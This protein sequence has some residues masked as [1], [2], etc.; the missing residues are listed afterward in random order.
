[1]K[2]IF[3]IFTF[4]S[5]FSLLFAG[6]KDSL[7]YANELY[8]QGEYAL[9]ARQYEAIIAGKS[10]AP[11]IY[12]N[13]GNAYYKM[14]ETGRAI[15]NYERALHLSPNYDDAKHNLELTKLKIVDNIPM[16]ESF[17][18]LRWV[19]DLIKTLSSNHW[20]YVS[21]GLFA[22]ALLLIFAF[23]FGSSQSVRKSSF[24]TAVLFALLSVLFFRES[25]KTSL[26]TI[27]RLSLW[28]AL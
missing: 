10:V 17:F 4:I 25:V 8:A 2:R 26:K 20:L 7:V 13:L 14:N 24:Y 3:I 28:W 1:M 11:E 12:Y 15:L 19:E 18:L 22:A 16:N 5:A 21:V 23:L 27:I 6:Q 9:A